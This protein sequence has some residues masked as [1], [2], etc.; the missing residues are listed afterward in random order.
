M[1]DGKRRIPWLALAPLLVFVALS[2]LFLV[3]LMS[4]AD[5]ARLPSAL[6]G[7][8]APAFTLP[9]IEGAFGEGFSD[10]DLKLGQVTLVNVFASWCVPCREEHPFLMQMSRDPKLKALGVRLYGLNYKDEAA[11]AR[12]FLAQYGNPYERAGADIK[13]RAGIDWGVYGVP[14]TF[15]VR[16]DGSIAYKQIGPI[17]QD[18]L[19]DKLMPAI[20]AA[21]KTP[22]S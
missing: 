13:G 6:I 15:V 3:R 1:S 22:R 18:A 5:T 19:R 16:G 17:S 7:K 10:A 9:A 2:G 12:G 14:E 11:N 21:A 8:Q 20:E 4:G